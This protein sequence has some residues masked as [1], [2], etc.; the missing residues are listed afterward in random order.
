MVWVLRRWCCS[1]DQGGERGSQWAE[2]LSDVWGRALRFQPRTW[3][4]SLQEVVFL[5]LNVC[6]FCGSAAAR[7]AMSL[8]PRIL[9]LMTWRFKFLEEPCGHRGTAASEK[10]PPWRSPRGEQP[11]KSCVCAGPQG[12]LWLVHTGRGLCATHGSGMPQLAQAGPGTGPRADW[13]SCRFLLFSRLVVFDPLRP[14]DHS[15]LRALCLS[16]SP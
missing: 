15:T 16:L 9:S 6:S 11:A 14:R 1:Q 10:R 5:L 2:G 7:R 12:S 4:S 8:H 3:P 13:H